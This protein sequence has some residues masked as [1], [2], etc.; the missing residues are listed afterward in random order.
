MSTAKMTAAAK[1]AQGKLVTEAKRRI[2]RVGTAAKQLED[3]LKWIANNK[4]WDLLGYGNFSEM[5]EGENGYACPPVLKRLIAFALFDE[6]MNTRNA[7]SVR[8][9][10]PDGH[11]QASIAK[12]VG[13]GTYTANGGTGASEVRTLLRQYEVGID[14]RDATTG[15]H[16]GRN[17]VRARAANRSVGAGPDD[18]VNSGLYLPKRVRDWYNHE[19]ATAITP[20]PTAELYRQVLIAHMDKVEAGRKASR[21]TSRSR[22]RAA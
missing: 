18:L 6:G 8:H 20:V 17:K 19:A 1:A 21:R 11:T 16:E 4:A 9:H 3:D 15:V 10:G 13:Y 14:P 5:F 12:A 7:A 22:G 2:K